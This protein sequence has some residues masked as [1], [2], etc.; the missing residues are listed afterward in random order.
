MS[1]TLEEI[2]NIQELEETDDFQEEIQE[3]QEIEE[4][5]R[6]QLPQVQEEQQD[7]TKMIMKVLYDKIKEPALVTFLMLVFT[8]PL[9]IKLIFNLPYITVVEKT[10]SVNVMLAIS[11]GIA[12][13]ILRE[14][15]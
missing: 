10:I 4:I 12:F 15:I 14:F 13:F 8:H 2:D 6:R 7:V 11:T 3:I 5:P 9:L 1:T